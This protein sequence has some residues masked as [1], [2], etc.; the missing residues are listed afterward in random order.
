MRV[1]IVGCAGGMPRPNTPSS[2]YLVE[3]TQA[4]VLLDCGPGVAGPVAGYISP[5]RLDAVVI[6]HMHIDHCH[7][8]LPLGK[9]MVPRVPP[10]QV[11]RTRLFVP[12]GA[13]ATLRQH[14]RLYPI[15]DGGT[16][17]ARL[18]RV[19][20]EVFDVCEYQPDTSL[21]INGA[22]LDMISM[23]HRAPSCGIRVSDGA[24]TLAYSGDAGM[25]D[26]LV[27]LAREADL[28]LC[29]ATLSEPETDGHGHLCGAQAGEVAKLAQV[30][31]LVLTHMV[32][33]DDVW[34][35]RLRN[36]AASVFDGLIDIAKP[37]KILFV[38][39]TDVGP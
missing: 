31:R 38:P 8:L 10:A 14:A 23:R 17:D 12:P 7:D 35:T 29:D 18:D 1:T 2:G 13:G 9:S 21:S 25:D 19:F 22:R 37:G 26:A 4:T 3:T 6:T 36:D 32:R 20:D 16:H 30:A 39:G 24:S 28:L 33:D 27:E 5:E 34:A 11:G 15:G